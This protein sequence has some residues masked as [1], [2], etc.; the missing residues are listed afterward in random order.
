VGGEFEFESRAELIGGRSD[1]EEHAV[2]TD[3]RK[4]MGWDL[5]VME[6]N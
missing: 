4:N 5:D 6:R 1:G 2:A 3:V